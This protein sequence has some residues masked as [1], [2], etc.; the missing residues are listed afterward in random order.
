MCLRDKGGVLDLRD[1]AGIKCGCGRRHQHYDEV[2]SGVLKRQETRVASLR[3]KVGSGILKRQ[4][5]HR[6][7]LSRRCHIV[8]ECERHHQRLWW[9]GRW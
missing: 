4:G 9:G 1:E 8:V 3:D 6:A 5:W 2:G 7:W